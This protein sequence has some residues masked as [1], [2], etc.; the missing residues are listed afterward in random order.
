MWGIFIKILNIFVPGFKV[1]PMASLLHPSGD[2][3]SLL[4]YRKAEQIYDLTYYFCKTFLSS[5]D[6]TVDQMIQAARSGKQNIA[7]GKEAGLTSMETEIKL[8]NVARASLDE[9]LIDYEDFLRVRSFSLWGKDSPEALF[10]RRKGGDRGLEQGYFLELARTRSPEVVA[11]MA[12][13]LIFQAK[14]LL[15]RQLRFLEEKFLKEGGLRERMS[16]RRR[17]VRNRGE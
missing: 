7:E 4:S 13:C 16:R 8:V 6:R 9:L 2:Y 17:G 14:Y 10:V 3:R 1:S 5:R 11:N 12:I 15:M